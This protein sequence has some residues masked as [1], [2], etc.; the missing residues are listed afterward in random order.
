MRFRQNKFS[1]FKSE[2][3]SQNNKVV[4]F[5]LVIIILL[6]IVTPLGKA[7]AIVL[8]YFAKPMWVVKDRL[9]VKLPT[10]TNYFSSKSNLYDENVYLKDEIRGLNDLKLENEVLRTENHELKEILSV[11]D[12]SQQRITSRILQRPKSSNFDVLTISSGRDEGVSV[13]DL[14]YEKGNLILGRVIEIYQD[15]SRVQLFSY[16]GIR[17]DILLGEE[18]SVHVATGE[19]GQNFS[20]EFPADIEIKVGDVAVISDNLGSI[21]ATVRE[22]ISARGGLISEAILSS[23]VNINEL[24]FVEVAIESGVNTSDETDI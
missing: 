4:I 20:V 6:G 14:V 19:G 7:F 10:A 8:N 5:V 1:D 9:E 3:R 23:V 13:G 24:R 15:S 2:R 17:T 16:N 21:M 18:R 22:I 12:Q 11:R